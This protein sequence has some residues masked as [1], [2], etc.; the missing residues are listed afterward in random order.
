MIDGKLV[1]FFTLLCG[2]NI[3]PN[4]CIGNVNIIAAFIAMTMTMT[5]NNV[6]GGWRMRRRRRRTRRRTLGDGKGIRCWDEYP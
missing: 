1:E 5:M 2:Q 4:S 6:Y 3:V